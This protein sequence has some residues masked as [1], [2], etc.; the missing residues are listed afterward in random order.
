MAWLLLA[1]TLQQPPRIGVEI[2]N[3]DLDAAIVGDVA[4][5]RVTVELRSWSLAAREAE[6]VLGAPE[7]AVIA[8]VDYGGAVNPD[9]E[10]AMEPGALKD[11]LIALRREAEKSAPRGTVTNTMTVREGP[12]RST[13]ARRDQGRFQAHDTR[14]PSM[15]SKAGDRAFRLRFWPLM[16]ASEDR[17]FTL[18]PDGKMLNGG[19]P[20]KTRTPGAPQRAVLYFVHR[21]RETDD[22][23][24]YEFPLSVQLQSPSAG[25]L[26]VFKTRGVVYGGEG[27]I[28]ASDRPLKFG[29]AE[30]VRWTVKPS[31]SHGDAATSAHPPYDM[32]W[33]LDCLAALD[34][35]AR[36]RDL[37][38]VTKGSSLLLADTALYKDLGR[39]VPA[40]GP[41][42][43]LKYDK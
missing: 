22:G 6:L 17:N 34:D 36:A 3:L 2:T 20:V 31:E 43:L 24:V 14:D 40:N 39:D 7:G 16:P 11:Q 19:N 41:S 4:V 23:L 21:L 18:R 30:P 42:R 38:V 12:A 13:V 35:P 15:I 1:L 33:A 5:T 8:E 9:V 10:V 28:D 26:P 32:A 29:R 37:K 25:R 27:T